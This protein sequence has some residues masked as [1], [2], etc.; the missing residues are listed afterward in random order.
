MLT[1]T[2]A[3]CYYLFHVSMKKKLQ[4]KTDSSRNNYFL[5]EIDDLPSV[6]KIKKIV[7]KYIF[8]RAQYR[9]REI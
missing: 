4:K 6:V 9:A 7:V 1:V 5:H 3:M 2:E 8:L